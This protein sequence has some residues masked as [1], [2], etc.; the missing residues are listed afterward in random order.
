[1]KSIPR[2]EH[3]KPETVL[4]V[5]KRGF[6]YAKIRLVDVHD[7][8]LAAEVPAELHAHVQ[9]GDMLEA[10]LWKEDVASF[11]FPLLVKGKI[12]VR[13]PIVFFA[14]TAN[15]T[16]TR[17]RKCLSAKVSMPVQFYP[18][19]VNHDEKRFHSEKIT[20]YDGTIVEISDRDAVLRC[21][22]D[23]PAGQLLNGHMPI[24]PHGTL[25]FTARV[26]SRRD[27]GPDRIYALEYLGMHEKQR[28]EI[29]DYVFMTYRE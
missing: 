22:M 9:E 17:E 2:T 13:L 27:E 12:T 14:H 3:L 4:R 25:E 7:L 24:G 23:L 8:F 11:E 16:A 26:A 21:A 5:Y 1:M 10:Y 19:S 15:V 6:G 18:I 28:A 29:L 20:L